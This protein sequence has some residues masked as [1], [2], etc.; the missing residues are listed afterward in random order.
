MS[1]QVRASKGNAIL[2]SQSST[3]ADVKEETTSPTLAVSVEPAAKTEPDNGS[4][5]PSSAGDFL[6]M[7]LVFSRS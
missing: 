7:G 2:Q 6:Q 3:E 5:T 1:L 4:S